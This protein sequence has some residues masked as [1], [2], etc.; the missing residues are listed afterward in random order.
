MI[1]QRREQ[2]IITGYK[3]YVK[4][5]EEEVHADQFRRAAP[6]LKEIVTNTRGKKRRSKVVI[7]PVWLP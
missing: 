3:R 6:E 1:L 2:E 7:I 5:F 4:L